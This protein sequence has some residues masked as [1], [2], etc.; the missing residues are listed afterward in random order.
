MS[1]SETVKPAI[2]QELS[3][4][5]KHALEGE[6]MDMDQRN[7]DLAVIDAEYS[8]KLPYDAKRLENEVMFYLSQS[9]EA[10]FEAG[11]RLILL[12]EHEGHGNF[13]SSLNRI[14]IERRTATNFMR[15]AAK[16]SGAKEKALSH[17]GKT[18]LLALMTE[19]DEDIDA[20]VDGGTLAGHNMDGLE[21]MSAREL[22][23]EL[24]AAKQEK[25]ATDKIIEQ[26]DKKINELD[27]DSQ[28]R[29]VMEGDALH[30][31]LEQD[32]YKDLMAIQ[33]DMRVLA[34][35]I[36]NITFKGPMLPEALRGRPYQALE[37]IRAQLRDIELEYDVMKIMTDDDDLGEDGTPVWAADF[38]KAGE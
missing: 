36:E 5:S 31:E 11:K 22:I 12:K 9:A 4:D 7:A 29:A 33:A 32:L 10:M 18:K 37:V 21:R 16:F 2:T 6:V 8:D 38:N 34:K 23:K 24:R 20:L 1:R 17:L 19:A 25:E 14:G 28:R 3:E 35:S 15:A 27:R 30:K 26:K 13:I